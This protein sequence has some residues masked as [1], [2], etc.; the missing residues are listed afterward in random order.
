M[1]DFPSRSLTEKESPP[2]LRF[3]EMTS[4]DKIFPV[5][6]MKDGVS[7]REGDAVTLRCGYETQY[8][9]VFLFWYKQQSE[10]LPPQFILWKGARRYSSQHIP[11]N[12]FTSRTGQDE[13]ELTIREAR[14]ADA[15]VYFCA[16]DTP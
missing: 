15:G 5:A 16:L 4:A 2:F 13:S 10:H 1:S 12:R 8:S 14:L 3:T 6:E 7:S 9:Y 11:D